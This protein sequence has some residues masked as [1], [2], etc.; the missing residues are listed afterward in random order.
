ML[1]WRIEKMARIEVRKGLYVVPGDAYKVRLKVLE[2]AAGL[3]TLTYIGRIQGIEDQHLI[4]NTGTVFCS[5]MTCWGG[6][7]E[8]NQKFE[9]EKISLESIDKIAGLN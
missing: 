8:T 5:Y 9:K 2:T 4:L 7:S 6:T 3:E 1:E